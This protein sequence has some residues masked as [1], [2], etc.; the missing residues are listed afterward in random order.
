MSIVIGEGSHQLI[1][2]HP[3]VGQLVVNTGADRI[4]WGYELNTAN[5]PT[6]GGE[7]VQILSCFVSTL[8]VQ[9]TVQ[10]YDDMEKFYTYFLT[11]LQVATQGDRINPVPGQSS[12]NEHPMKFEYPHRGWTFEII[13]TSVPG[14]RKA[15]DVVAPEWR[16]EAHIIDDAG[17]VSDLKDLVISE[18]QMKLATNN[19][20]ENFGLQ[21]KIRFLDENPFSDPWTDHGVDYADERDKRLTGISDAYSKLIPSYLNGDFDAVFGGLGSKPSFNPQAGKK[22]NTEGE[23][24]E[25][26][27]E[28]TAK[29]IGK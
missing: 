19:P 20:D 7:V 27:I 25:D 2:Y 5:F 6:Y 15:R 11:Y 29:K 13:P 16:L 17:D 23:A 22:G 1:F 12:Y 4:A 28:K 24:A 21:G 14:Y 9:G 10:T 26:A 8:E 18:A 3:F